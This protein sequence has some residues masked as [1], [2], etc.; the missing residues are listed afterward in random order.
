MKSNHY[1]FWKSI[2]DL[3]RCIR[4][5]KSHGKI[6]EIDEEVEPAPPIH[7]RCRC[8]IAVL[9][10][11]LAGKATNNGMNGADL[12]LKEF[13]K[14]PPYYISESEALELGWQNWLGNLSS[15][16]PGKML[17]KGVYKNRDGHLPASE[18][19]VWYEADINYTSGFR[20]NSRILFSNDG[21]IFVTYD[22]YHTFSEIV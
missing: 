10:A 18:G 15:V 17:T 7:E 6:Y 12:W 9:E 1:K 20:G 19:R 13:G 16:A 2:I 14:L 8:V 21:L 4:C 3:K 22:H 11:I 5:K